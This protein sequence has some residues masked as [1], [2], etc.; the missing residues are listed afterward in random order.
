MTPGR[1]RRAAGAA[2]LLAAALTATPAVPS[3][4]ARPVVATGVPRPLQLAVSGRSLLV[5]SPGRHGDVAGE[6]FRVD[7]DAER[8]VDLTSQPRVG[9]PFG[10]ARLAA[11]G[12][13]AFHPR[14]RE[15]FLGEENG[16]RVHRLDDDG[17]LT[18]YLTG[19]RRLI[20][21]S[22]LAVDPA[23]RLV[24]VD[25]VDPLLSRDDE[26]APPGL[27]AFRDDEYRGPL[28]FRLTLD[29]TLA[30]PRRL[31][32]QV[33][34]FPRGWGGRAGGGLLPRFVSVAAVG[35]D[36]VLL[37]SSGQLYRLWSDG[38]L[39]PFARLPRGQYQRTNMAV[40]PDGSIWVSGGFWVAS[41]YRVTTDG[42][43]TTVAD[44]L[45]DPQGIAVDARGNVYLAESALHRVIR[46]GGPDM[47]PHTPPRS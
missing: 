28:V 31:A 30:L 47:A 44:H 19:A 20:G 35:D 10:D 37:A 32:N 6:L 13:L 11:L 24:I 5:L 39:T 27:E 26:S 15:V 7:L 1:L 18:L 34:V 33:P 3:G 40:A 2:G 21:G 36:L 38:T 43:V 45:A 23:G 46:V 42:V 8:P 16:T 22:A 9:I 14:T 29:P 12:S 4:P 25:H 17:R 41:V